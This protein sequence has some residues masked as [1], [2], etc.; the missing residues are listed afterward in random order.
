MTQKKLTSI[1]TPIP[2]WDK[3]EEAHSLKG[4]IHAKVSVRGM[5]SLVHMVSES[6]HAANDDVHV[7]NDNVHVVNDNVHQVNVDVHL[8]NQRRTKRRT[9]RRT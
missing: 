8:V 2:A 3:R 5:N 4:T 1:V 6:A 9:A 7:V